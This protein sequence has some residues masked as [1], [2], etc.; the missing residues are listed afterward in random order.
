MTIAQTLEVVHGL[1]NNVKVVMNDGKRSVDGIWKALDT[2]QQIVSDINKMKRD[3]LKRESR[4]WLSP[5]DPSP[6]YNIAREIHRDETATWFCEGS[7]FAEWNA[8]GSLLWIHGKPGSG[9]TILMSTVISEIEKMRKAGLALMAYFFFDFRDTQKQHRRD[10]LSSLLFQLS[11]RSDFCHHIF[12]RFYVD[13]DEGAQQPSDGALAQ[14][15]IDMLKVEGQPPIYIIIDALDESPNISGIPTAR[16]RVLQFLEDLVGSQL[17]NTHICVSSRTEV[18]IRS[19]LEP[20]ASFQVLLHEERGQM[21]DISAYIKSVVHSDRGM[22]RWTVENQ[23]LVIASLSEKADGMFRWVYCLLDI[24]RR[25]FP[26]SIPSNLE[27]LPET[28]DETYERI[29]RRIDK[30]KRQFAHRLFQ[31]LAV[32]VRPLLVEELGAILAFRFDAGAL[33][34]F[35]TGWRLGDVEEAVLSACSTLITVIHVNGSRIVQFSHSSVKEFLASDRLASASEDLSHYHI[36]PHQAHATLAQACLVVLLQLDD[37][38]D[39]GSIKEV[40]LVNYAAQ[41]W[42]EHGQ[43]ENVSESFTIRDATIRLFDRKRPQFA[44]WI[45][46]YDMDDPWREPMPTDHPERPEAPPLYYAIHCRLRW[47]I[48]HLIATYPRHIDA[49]GGYYHSSW[50]AAFHIGDFD[51]AWSLLRSGADVNAIDNWGTNPLHYAAEV[52]RADLVRSLLEHNVD[53]DLP[54]SISRLTALGLTSYVGSV[55]V[56]RLLIRHGA[57][58]NTRTRDDWTPLNRASKQGH[59]NLVLFLIE[60]GA[61]VNSP[62]HKGVTPLHSAASKG[63]L[64]IVKVLIESGADFIRHNDDS[65]TPLDLAFDNGELEV[66]NFLSGYMAGETSPAGMVKSHMPTLRPRYKPPNTTVQPLRKPREKDKRPDSERP[67]L[68][69][70]SKDGWLAIIQSLLDRGSDINERDNLGLTALHAASEYGKLEV[71][72]LLIER[73]ANVNSRSRGGLTPLAYASRFGHLEVTRL[74]LDHGA[75]VN[76]KSRNGCSVLHAASMGGYLHVALLLVERGVDVDAPNYY[77]MTPRQV[78]IAYGSHGISKFLSEH[79]RYVRV[80]YSGLWKIQDHN[81]ELPEAGGGK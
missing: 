8:K 59:L 1:V 67:S 3:C 45:W 7:V 66:L 32:S 40:P 21:A 15:L 68:H 30:V 16:E 36:I 35:N 19:I 14:C 27:H 43:F 6:N 58:V 50:I 38:I 54:T 74:L 2:M 11:A 47:L 65:K 12:S 42:F 48:E 13:H 76:A 24:L 62:N 41:H 17:P 5:P 10:L 78:A 25:C 4:R 60:I 20:L 33:P 44:A 72:K 51:I 18:D 63:H 52:G 57:D 9:K 39:R 75:N 31:C 26:A 22:R 29:L 49:R 64:D 37:R 80:K 73:G 28:L 79:T 70:A 69:T 46:I 56:S 23:Q 71:A 81:P 55:E 53:V 61:D 77:G 34:Q